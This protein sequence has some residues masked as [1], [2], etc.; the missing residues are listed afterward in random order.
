M[1]HTC[2]SVREVPVLITHVVFRAMELSSAAL[3]CALLAGAL[4]I[5]AEFRRLAGGPPQ[6]RVREL[7][8]LL[9]LSFRHA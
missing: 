5:A 7:L 4:L 8:E 3:L 9:E 2:S 6:E 1:Y